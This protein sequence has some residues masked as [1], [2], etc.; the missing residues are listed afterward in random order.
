MPSAHD[1]R[2]YA[3]ECIDMAEYANSE[4]RR[5]LLRMAEVWLELAAADLS[6][7]KRGPSDA[8]STDRVH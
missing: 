3:E 8:T 4:A 1:Y 5:T 2:K 7:K 6:N